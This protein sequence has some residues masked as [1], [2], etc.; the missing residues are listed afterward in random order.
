MNATTKNHLPSLLVGILASYF[1]LLLIVSSA[2]LVSLLSG[3]SWGGWWFKNAPGNGFLSAICG[4]IIG[5]SIYYIRKLYKTLHLPLPEKRL[6]NHSMIRFGYAIYYFARPVFAGAFGLIAVVALQAGHKFISQSP[7][8]KE[9]N[10]LYACT[11]LG[12]FIGFSCGK[13]IKQLETK[14]RFNE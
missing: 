6:N 5:S 9:T 4:S 12:F 11:T 8:L 13:L 10:F 1:A 14:I 2:I 3:A 7:D